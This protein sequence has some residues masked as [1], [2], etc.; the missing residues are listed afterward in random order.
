VGP[1]RPDRHLQKWPAR[2]N[3][4]PLRVGGHAKNCQQQV[5]PDADIKDRHTDSMRLF[6]ARRPRLD[7]P[8]RRRCADAECRVLPHVKSASGIAHALRPPR[9]HWTKNLS[10]FAGC[11]VNDID[12][13]RDR[14][15]GPNVTVEVVNTSSR[16]QWQRQEVALPLP[17]VGVSRSLKGARLAPDQLVPGCR[18]GGGPM[19]SKRRPCA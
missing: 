18:S 15:F 12:A 11:N 19:A 16:P 3:D 2:L 10:Q 6:K 14:L 7:H 4:L 17:L 8:R 9:N 5:E 1:F 13:Q